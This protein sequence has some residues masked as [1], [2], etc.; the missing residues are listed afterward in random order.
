M[1]FVVFVGLGRLREGVLALA[2]LCSLFSVAGFF[3]KPAQ[4]QSLDTADDVFLETLVKGAQYGSVRLSPNGRYLLYIERGPIQMSADRVVLYDLE[5]QDGPQGRLLDVGNHRVHW[6]SWASDENFLISVSEVT[7]YYSVSGRR[8]R[9][10]RLLPPISRVVTI[11]RATLTYRAIL[12]DD[13]PYDRRNRNLTEITDILPDDPAHV[14]MPAY[15]NQRFSLFR[16]NIL[17]GEQERL[18]AGTHRTIAWFAD[19]GRAVMRVSHARNFRTLKFYARVGDSN[20]WRRI[21]TVRV[22][23]LLGGESDFE[24]AGPTDTPGQIFVRARPEGYNYF[25]IFRY[26][27]RSGEYLETIAMRDDYDISSAFINEHTGE[28]WGYSYRDTQLQF[29]FEDEEFQSLFEEIVASF[30]EN[31]IVAPMSAGESRLVVRVTG[32]AQS[33]AYYLVDTERDSISPLLSDN[34]AL[35]DY[36]LGTMQPV[37]YAARDGQL[38]NAYL[39]LPANSGTERP[40]LIVMPHG[41]PEARDS[42]SFDP[43]VQFLSAR[44]YAVFQPNFRGSSGYGRVYAETGYR[45]WGRLMQDDVTDG[46][47]WLIEGGE[48]D[49]DRVCIMGFS[50]GGYAALMGAALTPDLYQCAISGAPVTEFESF[51]DFKERHGTGVRDYW[52][53]LLGHPRRDRNQM[54]EVMPVHLADEMTIPIFLYHAERDRVVPSSQSRQ[55]VEAFEDA[56]A[57]FVYVEEPGS[58]HNWSQGDVPSFKRSMRNIEAFLEDAMDGQ[59]DE[60]VPERVEENG[61]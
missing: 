37:Q 17:T 30:N 52:I 1:R 33:A 11:D 23:D 27:L 5:H 28:Y 20:N 21:S 13:Q 46:V 31:L 55:M 49:P 7:E 2:L 57:E 15:E 59:I 61:E 41:G 14:L 3:G 39:T 24:W 44:G 48:I 60:F 8:N 6:A 22:R 47:R 58:A 53:D 26:D 12:F 50:Y 36:P 29:V 19:D 34:A 10:R 45:Q 18:E 38:I 9:E 42:L 32:A 40:P 16:V 35:S 4:A 43:V 25:G 51:I 56:G 54:R